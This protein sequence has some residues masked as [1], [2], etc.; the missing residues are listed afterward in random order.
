MN[1]FIDSPFTFHKCVASFVSDK[2]NTSFI[3]FMLILS[4]EGKKRTKAS[5][6]LK[7]HKISK[8]MKDPRHINTFC[9]IKVWYS[10][11]IF[12]IQNFVKF[13]ITYDIS[14]FSP[15]TAHKATY[16]RRKIKKKILNKGL[17]SAIF[18]FL[19]R[20]ATVG[21]VPLTQQKDVLPSCEG[22]KFNHSCRCR[23][24]TLYSFFFYST[25]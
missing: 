23:S 9:Y 4:F 15:D 18:I 13:H 24:F 22:F 3:L 2:P 17:D 21:I 5:I 14:V 10:I 20:T 25:R 7:S 16:D 8:I 11:F 6:S 1:S 19:Q 12:M